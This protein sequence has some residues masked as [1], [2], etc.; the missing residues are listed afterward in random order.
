MADSPLSV[1]QVNTADVGGGAEAVAWNLFQA[2][3]RA[4]N[5]SQLA[6]GHR[7]TDDPDVLPIQSRR[8][9]SRLRQWLARWRGHEDFD[10]PGTW[11]LLSLSKRPPDVIHCH[12]LHGFY[13]DL[14]T[15]A[16]LSGHVP[17]VVTLHDAWLLSGHCAHSFDCTRWQTGC[18]NCPDLSI[19]PSVLRD[20]TAFNWQRKAGI[21]R[22]SRLYVATPSR[23]LMDKVAQSLVAPAIVEARVVPNGVDLSVFSP[24]D[25]Q[26]ARAATGLPRNAAILLH[27]ANHV[28][29]NPFKDFATLRRSVEF[30]ARALPGRR[31]MLVVV[32]DS[33]RDE[34]LGEAVVRFVPPLARHADIA[35]YYRAADVYVHAA[36][37]DT[38]PNTVIEALAC[39]TPVVATAVGGIVEQVKSVAGFDGATIAASHKT[40]DA[41]EATGILVEQANAQAMAEAVSVILDD[42][43]LARRMSHHAARDARQR[44]SLDRQVES[45]LSWYRQIVRQPA[46][47]AA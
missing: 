44:F 42:H 23:W 20:G 14:N 10:F 47:R 39:G 30:A 19:Y 5:T 16:W 31:L 3:R 21:M 1:L 28:R 8:G 35:D 9:K 15:L 32:G 40:C 26:R 41:D 33:G 17:V 22:A 37:A 13:F 6:V 11:S 34:H 24:G 29:T 36:R 27:V 43:A 45:Y 25:K 12:N 4:G 7:R 2:Y 18:G 46:S 38:F